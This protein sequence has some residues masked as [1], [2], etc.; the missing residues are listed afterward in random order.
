MS[1]SRA[2]SR[3]GCDVVLF[4]SVLGVRP[5]VLEWADRLREAGHTVHVPDLYDGKAFST[6]ADGFQH[7]QR[8]G[9]IPTLVARTQDAVRELP[10]ALVYAG[11]SNGAASAE[12]LAATRPG[13]RGAILMHGAL[14]L[15]AFGATEWPASVPVQVHGMVNDPF[16]Q[17]ADIDAFARRVR[18]S[19]AALALHDYPGAGHLFAD[20]ELP[21]HDPEAAALMLDRVLEWLARLETH[22][23]AIGRQPA[24]PTS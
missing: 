14:P 12:L 4:H 3:A 11:F 21:D 15:E 22:H 10:P 6:F 20:R 5:A 9:G 7:L 1:R 23:A 16:R 24:M 18:E 8:I 13:A 17:Q 19:G 2:G